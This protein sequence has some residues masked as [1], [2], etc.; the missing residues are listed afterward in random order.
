MTRSITVVGGGYAGLAFI[1]Q[2]RARDAGVPI[3]LIDQNPFHTMLIETHQVAAA[4]RSAASVL[5]PFAQMEGFRFIQARVEGLDPAR[6]TLATTAG[7][8]PYDVLVLAVG[9]VD[10]DFGV[11]GVREHCL[12]LHGAADALAIRERLAALPAEAP[13]IIAGGGLTGVELAAHMALNRPEGRS[14]TLVEGSPSLLPGLPPHL[15]RAARRRLGH[16]GVNVITGAPVTRVEAGRAY[17][18]DSTALPFGLMVWA[19]GVRAHPLV[20]RLVIPTDRAGRALVGSDLRTPLPDLY[21]IGDSAAG[22]PPSAQAAVQQG[23]ALADRLT[24]RMPR[25]VRLKGTLVDLGQHQAVGLIGSL[26][27]RGWLPGLLKRVN[28][29]LWVRQ[30]AGWRAAGRLLLGLPDQGSRFESDPVW[31]D[32]RG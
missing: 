7:E 9:S 14:L 25:P 21:V 23:R 22:H 20:A 8:V 28:E 3:T 24:G 15:A 17:L 26:A 31:A 19:C 12:M 32:K 10:H 5:L 13:V 27:L 18:A 1:R 29:A 4:S 2:L 11:E 6:R 16:L 30:I